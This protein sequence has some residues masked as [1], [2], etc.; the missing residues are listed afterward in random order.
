MEA[1]FMLETFLDSKDTEDRQLIFLDELPW[2]DTPRSGFIPAFENFWNGWACF[3]RNI[4]VIV[5]G[6][7]N[8]W[9][10]DNLINN[11]GGLYGRVTY[12]IRLEPFTMREC[13]LYFEQAGIHLSR[14]DIAQSYMAVG[15]IPYYLGYFRKELSLAQN[16]DVLF[17]SHKAKLRDEFDRL[18]ESV[19][20]RPELMKA[21][22]R[23]LHT[24]NAGFSRRD[25]LDFLPI[26]EGETTSRCL[27]ALVASEFIVKYTPFGA[28]KNEFL[29]K[30]TDPFCLF[31]LKFVQDSDWSDKAYWTNH[32]SSQ[33]VVSWRGLA[34]ENICFSH[35]P[36]I[37][38][39]WESPAY[40]LCSL[41]GRK[42]RTIPKGCRL[43][44]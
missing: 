3:H 23:K 33:E 31:Y 21:I 34:F 32:L 6:S 13:E 38:K 2:M 42:I 43:T 27:N 15:G 28:K 29:Y 36:Q 9:I 39:R 37:K 8:S 25:I 20:D 1:F 5:C 4:M 41:P 30:L 44:C 19:F 7:A 14:Y 18:F 24:K 22:V 40:L 12:E 10:L 11:R 35:I 16:L 26:Q 17:F